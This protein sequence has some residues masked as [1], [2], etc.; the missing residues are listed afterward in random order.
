[1]PPF[2]LAPI[3]IRQLSRCSTKAIGCIF[4]PW[5]PLTVSPLRSRWIRPFLATM[6][7]S[8]SRETGLPL[9]RASQV[10]RLLFLNA[11]SPITPK[12]PSLA[13]ECLFSDGFRLQQTR[14]LGHPQFL[15]NEAESSSL[16]L[17]LIDSPSQASLWGL[18]LSAPGRLHVGHSI[19]MLVS[20][21]TNREV[22]LFLTHLVSWKNQKTGS[23]TKPNRT[24]GLLM[25][26]WKEQE[27]F[28]GGE[29]LLSSRSSRETRERPKGTF[30]RKGRKGMPPHRVGQL[31][32]TTF[33]D[34]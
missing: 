21:Q 12:D 11:P 15:R 34:S 27:G 10:P 23:S 29:R 6:R 7:P 14:Q 30:P 18:L 31:L 3:S 33:L 5:L 20:F 2:H 16:L 22:R 8:D 32:A 25:N 28:R 17:W 4:S 24:K 19:V 26:G 1:M 13:F 9:P